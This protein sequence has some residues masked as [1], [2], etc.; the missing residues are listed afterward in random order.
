MDATVA[1]VVAPET[2]TLLLD[3]VLPA[4][5]WQPEVSQYD[6]GGA[7]VVVIDLPRVPSH[8][9]SVCQSDGS[10]T[11]SGLCP[12]RTGA[13][14]DDESS[15]GRFQTRVSVPATAGSS[16]AAE[17]TFWRELLIIRLP[18]ASNR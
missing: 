8:S 16:G 5:P 7:H 9:L 17:I 13:S 3:P 11:V 6:D 15:F 2:D 18:K 4:A 10:L 1:P 14:P 12:R